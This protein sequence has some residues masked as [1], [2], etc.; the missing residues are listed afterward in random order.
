MRETAERNGMSFALWN[1][2]RGGFDVFDEKTGKWIR[3]L[4]EA[5]APRQ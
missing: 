1:D 4:L 5:L 2:S 3:P